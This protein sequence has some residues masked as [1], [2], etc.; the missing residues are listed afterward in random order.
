MKSIDT[1]MS[2]ARRLIQLYR[3]SV[4][5]REESGLSVLRQLCE[6]ALLRLPPSRLG[7]S[8]YFDFR[9]FSG[10]LLFRE[11]RRFVGWRGEP[12]LDRAN[13]PQWHVYADDKILLDQLLTTAGLARP[14]LRCVFRAAS[15]SADGIHRLERDDALADWLRHCLDYPLFAK[16][17][18]AGFGHGAFLIEGYRDSDDSLLLGQ[19]QVVPVSAFVAGLEDPGRCGYLFQE[20]LRPHATLATLN[21]QRLS[22]LRV[23]TLK[24]LDGPAEIFRVVWKVPRRHNVIDNF[25]N[26]STGNLLAK[27]DPHTGRV[28][29]V[30]QG[31]GLDLRELL[32]HPD[33][34]LSFENLTLPDWQAMRATTLAAAELMP[35]FRFQHWDIALT[36]RGPV[37]LEVNLYGT[38]GLDLS[39]LVEQRGLLEPRLLALCKR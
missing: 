1:L 5:A 37:P 21:C 15:P 14:R 20:C 7:F 25:E 27:V 30:I 18:H 23:M 32:N 19:G 33:S 35:G 9:L 39:Q 36:D 29:R 3:W 8:E 13:A 2:R 34:G 17:A 28:L 6:A 11:K 26:G 10:H 31:F 24:P 4:Q 38:T 16:P 12:V 22:S